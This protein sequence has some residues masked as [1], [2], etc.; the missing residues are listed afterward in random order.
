MVAL[1]RDLT[2]REHGLPLGPLQDRRC[3]TAKQVVGDS[4]SDEAQHIASRGE[5][6]TSR[7]S[8]WSSPRTRRCLLKGCEQSFHPGHP[9][10][11]Y[12]GA[13]CC[14][15]ARQWSRW[16]AA[17]RYRGTEHGKACRREQSW[18]YRR[19]VQERRESCTIEAVSAALEPE[20]EGHHKEDFSEKIPC[21]R[22]GCYERFAPSQRWPCRRFCGR[23]CRAALR[24]VRRRE[25]QWR[26]RFAARFRWHGRFWPAS[27]KDG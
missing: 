22:P 25:R 3:L 7:F 15:R 6:S 19:R 21:R 8:G 23:L 11:R 9:L 2:A 14:Q 17:R 10:A 26:K 13:A 1:L 24:C 4:W 18:R 16:R 27:A 20:C 12:C 5:R